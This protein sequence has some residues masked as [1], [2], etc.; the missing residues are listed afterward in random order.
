MPQIATHFLSQSEVILM[1]FLGAANG[2]SPVVLSGRKSAPAG[3][4]GLPRSPPRL[5]GQASATSGLPSSI[6]AASRL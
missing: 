2:L 3:L 1:V 4:R 5:A 6:P